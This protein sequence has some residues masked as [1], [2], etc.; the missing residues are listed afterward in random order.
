ML[1]DDCW[2][3]GAKL[4]PQPEPVPGRHNSRWLQSPGNDVV[5]NASEWPRLEAYVRG[6][7]GAFADDERVLGWDLYN[8]VTNGFLPAQALPEGAREAEIARVMA[9]FE[10]ARPQHLRLLELAF[11]WARAVLPSQPLTAGAYT[12]DREMNTILADLS[13]V[14]SFHCYE[15][16][17]A[18]EA[19]IERLERH[20]RPMLC[21]EF[22]S[23]PRSTFASDLPVLKRHGVAAYNWGFVNGRTQTHIAWVPQ[24][25]SSVWFH[26][27]LRRD[28]SAYDEAE[29]A[30]LRRL[31]SGT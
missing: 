6:V 19:L 2:H 29:V 4:G 10:R 23:R 27:I 7:V 30:L 24:A 5:E 9:H 14:I 13:D 12:R 28:G 18:M 21:T 22:M 25:D 15:G 11:E 26:D 20:G 3:G 8:E 31:T 17:E 16:A 1:F